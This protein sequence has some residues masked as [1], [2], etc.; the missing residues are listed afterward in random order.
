MVVGGVLVKVVLEVGG[1]VVE[2]L[3]W[4]CCGSVGGS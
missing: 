2:M 3:R 4:G 1:S